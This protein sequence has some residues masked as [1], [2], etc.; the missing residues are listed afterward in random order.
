MA[1]VSSGGAISIL[2]NAS[3][4]PGWGFG[5]ILYTIGAIHSRWIA[6]NT[7]FPRRT[8]FFCGLQAAL[9]SFPLCTIVFAVNDVYD[10]QSDIRNPRKQNQ[11][12]EGG[13]L[14]PDHHHLVLSAARIF[15]AIIFLWSFS[16]LVILPPTLSTSCR[17]QGPLIT[18]LLLLFSWQY[19]SPP[20]RFKEVPIF[21]SFSNGMIVWLCWALGYVAGG[22]AL[23][24]DSAN[25]NAT[26]GWFLAFCTTGIHAL[27]AASD[28]EADI[29]AEQRTIATVLG[30]R[31]AAAFSAACFV[32]ASKTVEPMSFVGIYS[33]VGVI[34]SLVPIIDPAWT[35]QTFRAIVY[36]SI[37]GALG[38]IVE[39]GS[40]VVRGRNKA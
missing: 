37:L 34:V 8:I 6:K 16:A 5:P 1:Q 21:D 22:S 7:A 18:A 32:I 4:V 15:T 23:F 33:F 19:S 14:L 30:E 38:W 12:L 26:K 31:N 27:G 20:F 9:L 11:S 2:V 3:R 35:H 10:Y 24:G 39:R 36:L 25:K 40:S 17:L 13:V 28:I 29:V